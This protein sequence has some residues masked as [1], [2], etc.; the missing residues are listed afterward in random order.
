MIT[1]R[2]LVL[3]A[4][5]LLGLGAVYLIPQ[6]TDLGPAG[7]AMKLPDAVGEWKSDADLPVT[8]MEL[9]GLAPD[10]KFARR[11]YKNGAGDEIFVSIVL[12]GNDM[13]N[14]IHRPERCLAAQG[15]TVER[16]TRVLVPPNIPDAPPLEVTRLTDER[17]AHA[18]D[19]RTV[20]RR[21][22]NY[23]WF[24]GSHDVTASHWR[25]TLIDVE[26]RVLR[27]E[28][29]RWAYVTVAAN[30]TDN[31]RPGGRNAADTAE[32]MENFI[33]RIVPLFEKPEGYS[34]ERMVPQFENPKG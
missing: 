31:L 34:I 21:N 25:R 28:N 19:G 10:T 5:V 3:Q 11:F 15:W 17:E 8:P 30:I 2:L 13:A 1:N 6:K 20:P 22:L 26:D 33:G 9:A 14:S 16:A 4:I 32:M 23:Y 7:I 18:P 27:G 12:S 29:Q 24:I